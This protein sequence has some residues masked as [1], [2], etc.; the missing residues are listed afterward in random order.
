[1]PDGSDYYS[2]FVSRNIGTSNDARM[3]LPAFDALY[4]KSRDLPHGPA[5]TKLF[6]EMNDMIYGY[7][8]WILADYPYENVLAQPWLK[9]YKQQSV[10]AA[11]VALLRRGT[12]S[13]LINRRIR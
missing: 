12:A 10:R 5:R 3:R 6:D 4:D 2:Y 1:M 13:A 8:P 9:G 11:P 7:A